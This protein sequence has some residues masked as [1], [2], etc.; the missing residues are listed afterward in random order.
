MSGSAP[1]ATIGAVVLAAGAGVRFG[2]GAVPKQFLPL[3]GRPVA[4]R[5]TEALLGADGIGRVVLVLPRAGFDSWRARVAPFLAGAVSR[6][7]FVPGGETRQA[8]TAL[9]LE[10]LEA[11]A[12]GDRAFPEL[13]MVHDGSRPGV[14]AAL[15]ARVA[16]AAARSG[17]AMPG[18]PPVDALWRLGADGTAVRALDRDRAT[19]AQTP[20]CFARELLREAISRAS[21]AGFA[22]ADEAA[23]V[24]ERGHPVVVVPGSPRNLKITRREDFGAVAGMFPVRAEPPRIGYGFDVHRFDDA[25]TLR[26]GGIDFP[27]TPAL[28]GHSDGDAVLHALTDAILGAVAAPD[29]GALFPSSDEALR[30][31]DSRIFLA[32]ALE[33][34]AAAGYAPGQADLTVVAETPRLAPR[35]AEMRRTLAALLGLAGDS[36]GLKATTTDRLGFLGRGEGLAAKALVRLDA[37]GPPGDLSESGS[38]A[39][40]RDPSGFAG[41]PGFGSDW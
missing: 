27:G 5:A 38:V 34:A 10:A 37:V 36:V 7:S 25:G 13:V 26:L 15:I 2:G 12:R 6:L 30:D 3:A 9:G 18:L 21:A 29:L 33:L 35:I 20:Q 11:A 28:A 40:A 8:S 17:A 1:G 31:A 32:R 16:E 22:G 24:R 4:V 39:A 14:S 19:L 23:L 41:A